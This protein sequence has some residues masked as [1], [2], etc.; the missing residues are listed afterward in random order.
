[1][2]IWFLL[3]KAMLGKIPTLGGRLQTV[4]YVQHKAARLLTRQSLKED[5]TVCQLGP[6]L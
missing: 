2:E 3:A 4:S 6:A 1:M 5:S